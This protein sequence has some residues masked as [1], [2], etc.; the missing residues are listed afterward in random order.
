MQ[1]QDKEFSKRIG[2]RIKEARRD[3]G[4]TQEQLAFACGVGEKTIQAVER[5]RCRPSYELIVKISAELNV[6]VDFFLKD[7]PRISNT[8]MLLEYAERI[9]R[10]NTQTQQ[11]ALAMMDS[12]LELQ[13]KMES[14]ET[15]Q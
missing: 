9:N 4:I 3:K 1:K 13:D 10:M 5:G 14:E 2:S 12:L 7:G 8:Y 11:T 6:F 15:D